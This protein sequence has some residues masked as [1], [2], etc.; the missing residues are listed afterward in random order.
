MGDNLEQEGGTCSKGWI[1]ETFFPGVCDN[2]GECLYFDEKD[3]NAW[4]SPT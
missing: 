3:V 4:P 2:S 1:P